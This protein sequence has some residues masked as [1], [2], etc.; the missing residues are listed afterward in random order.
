[1]FLGIE[2]TK[3]M[4][5]SILE[6]LTQRHNQLVQAKRFDMNENDSEEEVCA[7]IHLLQIQKDQSIEL[8][9]HLERWCILLSVSGF[10]KAKNDL[11][12]F[13]SSLLPIVN[14]ERNIEPTVIKKMNQFISLELNHVQ[15]LDIT[16]SR[17]GPTSLVS[18]LKA[19]K[20]S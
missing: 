7:S 14:N 15:L 2:T 17:G 11:K 4:L 9:D 13:K 16:S 1:M 19:Y 5:G 10:N 18:F 6:K 20:T 8:Q 3:K 12:I